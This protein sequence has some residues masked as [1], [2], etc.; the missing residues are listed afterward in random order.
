M[1]TFSPFSMTSP[2]Y[3]NYAQPWKDAFENAEFIVLKMLRGFSIHEAEFHL[4]KGDIFLVF[5][6]CYQQ[7]SVPNGVEEAVLHVRWNTYPTQFK[8]EQ[9]PKN[10]DLIPHSVVFVQEFYD[11]IIAKRQSLSDTANK[12]DLA[13]LLRRLFALLLRTPRED[14]S[15]EV[16]H[17]ILDL[18]YS[19]N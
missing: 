7:L 17:R 1:G 18:L 6:V 4:K 3:L 2:V 10:P 15:M 5:N 9:V 12:D 16:L 14:A 19:L 11:M 13:D 8:G